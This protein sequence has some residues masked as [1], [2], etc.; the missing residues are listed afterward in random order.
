MP[1][2]LVTVLVSEPIQ[3]FSPSRLRSAKLADI[4]EIATLPDDVPKLDIIRYSA[5][6]HS[7]VTA[8]V[9]L[10]SPLIASSKASAI[11]VLDVYVS[12]GSVIEPAAAVP[13]TVILNVELDGI[14]KLA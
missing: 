11:A 4:D 14:V 9:K 3:D 12:A 6:V 1:V 13:S 7:T 10:A 5:P 8:S 2:V